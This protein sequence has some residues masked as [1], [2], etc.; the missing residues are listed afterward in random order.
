MIPRGKLY[1]DGKVGNGKFA[2]SDPY[3][4]DPMVSGDVIKFGQGV[5]VEDGKVVPAKGTGIFGVALSR[6]WANTEHFYEE[7]LQKDQWEKGEVV[8]I[9]REGTIAVPISEDVKAYENATV[10]SDGLFKP[11]SGSDTIVGLFVSDGNASENANLQ[12]R[13]QFAKDA[14]KQSDTSKATSSSTD[15]AAD[16]SKQKGG[17]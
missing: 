4:I 9:A 16:D 7:D 2:T 12:L 1:S 11:A 3:I 10:D 6:I 15:S 14:V 5:T 8:E 13:I 17:K